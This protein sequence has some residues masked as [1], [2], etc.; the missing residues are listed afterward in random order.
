MD[1]HL[2]KEKRMRLGDWFFLVG[3]YHPFYNILVGYQGALKK[4]QHVPPYQ[5]LV[6]V[7]FK[8]TLSVYRILTNKILYCCAS[9]LYS[10]GRTYLLTMLLF[11][12]NHPSAWGSKDFFF[13]LNERLPICQIFP[14]LLCLIALPSSPKY[15]LKCGFFHRT[16]FP[17]SMLTFSLS[18]IKRVPE[19]SCFLFFVFFLTER[20]KI[21]PN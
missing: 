1:L 8:E 6:Q 3:G 10:A 13:I 15:C 17:I 18:Y 20:I 19:S 4:Y 11:N 2:R 7:I 9:H 14:V 5:L 16:S 12:F 21:R